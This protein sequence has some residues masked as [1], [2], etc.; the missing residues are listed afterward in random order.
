MY[1]LTYIA[2]SGEAIG[3]DGPA[4]W[5]GQALGVRGSKWGYELGTSSIRFQSRQ[6]REEQ[7]SVGSLDGESLDRALAAFEADV[8]AGQPG[9]LRAGEW[10]QRAYVVSCSPTSSR[11]GSARLDLG[12]VLLDGVWRRPE[13]Y[14][15]F[16]QSG[17]ANGTKRYPYAYPYRYASAFG[18]RYVD[19]LEDPTESPWTMVIYG[20]AVSPQVS[21]GGN[22]HQFNVTVPE[23]GYLLVD[24]RPDPSVTLV[25]ADGLKADVFGCAV[26]GTGEGCGTY[27][28]QRI[29]RGKPEVRWND[30]FGFDLTVWHERGAPPYAAGDM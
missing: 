15:M 20:Y 13:E 14:H 24:A 25:T 29:P 22:V 17:D 19:A 12:V 5:S 28:F 21:I 7:L 23:G 16:P 6:A 11:R 9:V 26:R 1:R 4:V 18:V 3:L 2:A 10:E 30:S 27:A 8:A